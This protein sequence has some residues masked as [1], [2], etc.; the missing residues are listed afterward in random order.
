VSGPQGRPGGGATNGN[1][2]G[3]SAPKGKRAEAVTLRRHLEHLKVQEL[4]D[5][6]AFWTGE[7]NAAG[8]KAALVDALHGFMS[9]EGTV[10]R[11]VRTLTRK[12]LD[13]LLLLLKREHYASD[14]PGL[15]RRLPGEDP[16]QLEYHEAEAGLKALF[17]RGF[18]SE[19]SDRSLAGNGRVIFTVPHELGEM[20][21]GLFRE[22]TRRIA[23]VFSL[24]QHLAAITAS[25]RAAL[26][27]HFPDLP[28][29]PTPG[30]GA[31]LVRAHGAQPL[32]DRLS[33]DLRRVVEY[34]LER[35]GGVMR[36]TR[37]QKRRVLTELKWNRKDWATELERS[38]VGTVAR[39]NLGSYGIACDDDVL[40]VFEETLESWLAA[41][42]AEPAPRGATVL[43]SGCDLVADLCA[44]VEH[45]R[46]N[47][48]KVSREGEVY[49]AGRKRLLG[50]FVFRESFLLGPDAVWEEVQ[51][52]AEHLGLLGPDAEGFLELRP[53]A[54]RFLLRP[55]EEK[56][57]ALYLLALEQPGPRG[58][59]LHQH[60]QRKLLG[61]A[62][63]AE[64]T[65][66]WREQALVSLCRHRYLAHLDGLGIQERYRDRFFSAY[67][68]GQETPEDLREDLDLPWLKRLFALGMV[69][70]LTKDEQVLA[71]RLT[72]L[73]A[74]VL[75]AEGAALDTGLTPLLVNPDFEVLVLPEG[76]VSDVV[77]TLDGWSERV[78]TEDVVHF[79]LTRESVESAVGA[80]RSAEEFLQFLQARSRGGVPQNVRV[81]IQGWA[82]AVT[83]ATLERG[84]VLRAS[85][86][87]A[88]ARILAFP[89]MAALLVRRLGEGEALLREE[90]SDKRLL[91]ALRE[92]GIEIQG[93]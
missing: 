38:A 39:L 20:L 24:E 47:P 60:E 19:V 76:D 21:T 73:G 86:E 53:E 83:F 72:A 14:L 31:A 64:P 7:E 32:L 57:R 51:G 69:E 63:R 80:G 48:V 10:F 33:P 75:Q 70:A 45:A 5:V 85:D 12:V 59:S 61:D 50:G 11:R 17:R 66:W 4:K 84:V 23:S 29:R 8:Q 28:E 93:P 25:E 34:A 13:V 26:R 55:L 35:E 52:A 42:D 36:R 15:F 87:V 88:L 82:G 18:L 46:R 3:K 81:S 78:K 9:E 71:W 74:R 62:L 22:E 79:R 44:Y 92:R 30:E 89:Q 27:A 6:Y 40:V 68:S 2:N 90:P 77:H 43:R 58:R 41:R 91:S 49:K 16:V 56:V 65:R 1:G 54:A 37:W 67:F